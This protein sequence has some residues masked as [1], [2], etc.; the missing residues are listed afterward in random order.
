LIYRIDELVSGTCRFT[1]SAIQLRIVSGGDHQKNAVQVFGAEFN[2]KLVNLFLF[3]PFPD[4]ERYF[5]RHDTNRCP[6]FQKC[7]NLPFRDLPATD[8]QDFPAMQLQENRI[9]PHLS[10]FTQIVPEGK[11]RN[12]VFHFR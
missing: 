1:D 11:P 10:S 6:T 4:S 3:Y 7:L 12:L 2:A 8:H 9:V 5:L